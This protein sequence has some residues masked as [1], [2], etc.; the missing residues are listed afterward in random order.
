LNDDYAQ[1]VLKAG[2]DLGVTERGIV[3]GFATVYVESDWL[4]YANSKVPEST[5]TS[6]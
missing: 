2:R 1:A 3:I 5:E 4:N 6:A